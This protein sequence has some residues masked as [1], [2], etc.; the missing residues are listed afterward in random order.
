[1]QTLR[2]VILRHLIADRK[3]YVTINTLPVRHQDRLLLRL[4]INLIL[5]V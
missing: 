4:I 2:F 3:Q 1:M 5:N